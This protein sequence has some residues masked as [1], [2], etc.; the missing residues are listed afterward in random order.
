MPRYPRKDPP[1]GFALREF[2]NTR[3]WQ[4]YRLA[5]PKQES[6]RYSRRLQAVNW[7]WLQLGHEAAPVPITRRKP[8][9]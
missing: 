4:A 8:Q 5:N 7:C 3:Q 1:A 6:P 2:P 9:P